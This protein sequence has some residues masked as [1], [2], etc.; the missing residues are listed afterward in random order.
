MSWMWRGIAGFL[1]QNFSWFGNIKIEEENVCIFCHKNQTTF[2][3]LCVFT[4][5]VKISMNYLFTVKNWF[6]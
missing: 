6:D 4:F 1:T 3:G 5:E 2:F